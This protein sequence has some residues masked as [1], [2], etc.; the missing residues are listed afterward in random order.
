[1]ESTPDTGA[2]VPHV[3]RVSFDDAWNPSMTVPRTGAAATGELRATVQEV[4]S[5]YYGKQRT[6]KE[7]QRVPFAYSTSYALEHL[8]VVLTTGEEVKLIFKDSSR[9]ALLAGAHAAKPSFLYDPRREI[10]TYRQI[11]M[12]NALT[13]PICFGARVDARIDRY[14]LFIEYVPGWTL[15]E[16]EEVLWI[17]AARWVAALHAR[18]KTSDTLDRLAPTAHLLV[19]DRSFFELWPPRAL[20]LVGRSSASK[21]Q[22]QALRGIVDRY[23]VV[24]ERLLSLPYTFVHGEYFASNVIIHTT[25]GGH[26]VCPIDWEMAA[27]GPG[28]IDLAA[29]TA[30]DWTE[31]QRYRM[32]LA[33]W[34]DMCTPDDTPQSQAHFFEDLDYCR[35]HG[36]MQ[37]L[38]WSE[39]WKPPP[40]HAN[41]WLQEA[42]RL[43]E[44]LGLT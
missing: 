39:D 28:L 43:G 2:P 35:L 5:D 21:Y 33:Y 16:V 26:R 27:V 25:P 30:G 1:M 19:Y 31:D 15:F 17:E 7:L 10:E 3:H 4:L 38:G 22:R 44:R 14:W 13:T 11:L 12:P 24:V 41:N 34:T 36:A 29:L 9:E 42:V 18:F 40:E 6:I 20:E 23:G 32:A 37:W 8:S